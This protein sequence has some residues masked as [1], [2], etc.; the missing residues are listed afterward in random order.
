[1]ASSRGGGR[2]ED[3]RVEVAPN[4]DF[5]FLFS[6]QTHPLSNYYPSPITMLP[7]QPGE[8]TLFFATAEQYFQWSKAVH[9][10]DDQTADQ[11][12]ATDNPSLANSLGRQV[13]HTLFTHPRLNTRYRR[14]RRIKSGWKEWGM[15]WLA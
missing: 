11:I 8:E 12:L 6:G 3:E 7:Q 9:F 5:L 2:I 13:S 14:C 10:G 1:M 15:A 4:G